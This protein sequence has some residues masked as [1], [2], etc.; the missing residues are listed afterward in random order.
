MESL[1]WEGACVVLPSSAEGWWHWMHSAGH[2][3]V[4]CLMGKARVAASQL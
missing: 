1:C 2:V 4:L 3:S